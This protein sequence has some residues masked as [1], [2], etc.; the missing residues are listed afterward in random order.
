MPILWMPPAAGDHVTA[1]DPIPYAV[2]DVRRAVCD[3]IQALHAA[4]TADHVEALT[5]ELRALRVELEAALVVAYAT[6]Q[7]FYPKEH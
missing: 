3:F 5:Q 4:P 6:E 7:S 2:Q 1:R